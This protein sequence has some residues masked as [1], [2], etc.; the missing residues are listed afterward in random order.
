MASLNKE[1][2][3]NYTVQLVGTD[4]KRRSLRLGK[5]PKKAADSIKLRIESLHACAVAGLPWDADLA[6][7][8]GGLSDDLAAKLA[9][10]G[11]MPTRQSQSLGAFLDEYIS[12]RALSD[13][14]GTVD[15]LRWVVKDLVEFF[16]PAI[17]LRAVT[18]VMAEAFK[19]HYLERGLAAATVSRRLKSA[20]MFFA[21]ARKR[22]LVNESPFAE[23]RHKSHNPEGRLRYVS[24]ADIE[25]V[26]AAA[27]PK[28]QII[29]ALA[30]HG[31]L[32]CPSEVV[33]LKWE[34][35]NFAT[36]RMTVPSCKTAHLGKA[37]RT[38]P[39]FPELRPH[40]R[41]A[42]ELAAEGAV[43]VVP[44]N[45][46]EIAAKP[47]GWHNICLSSRFAQ[48]IRRAGLEVWPRIFQNL[49]A[50]KET[51]L[52][53]SHPIH[54]V[55]GWM[56]NTP[57]I[58]LAHYLQTLEGDFD[59]AIGAARR[60]GAESGAVGA[61]VVQFAVQSRA[62]PSGPEGTGTPPGMGVPCVQVVSSASGT[63]QRGVVMRHLS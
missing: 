9:G 42:F 27:K 63:R 28:W 18:P 34:H 33:A 46:M 15:S 55:T 13:K 47:G 39:I 50:S 29:I 32:R 17:G 38:V 8:V 12:G 62:G 57:Q 36:S 52:M 3:G 24:V 7:W 48:I 14:P 20:G 40:L 54:V 2:N 10:L 44:G 49:R 11:L 53:Q 26:I 22:K 16:D 5:V 51:D 25:K 4:G 61:E 58:A 59:K 21:V 45:L 1:P 30:R 23:V 56:G 35:V 37:W 19:R 43:Y 60:G 41:R 31:G 6:A